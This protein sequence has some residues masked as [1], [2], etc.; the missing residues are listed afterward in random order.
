MKMTVKLVF[1]VLRRITSFQICLVCFNI[2]WRHQCCTA[3]LLLFHLPGFMAE[4]WKYLPKSQNGSCCPVERLF[5]TCSL[6]QTTG[7]KVICQYLLGTGTLFSLFLLLRWKQRCE[8]SSFPSSLQCNSVK[9]T[10]KK[11]WTWWSNV[12]GQCNQTLNSGTDS[13]HLYEAYEYADL[14]F[15]WFV[16]MPKTAPGSW[17]LARGPSFTNPCVASRLILVFPQSA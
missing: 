10:S 1:S 17:S 16:F 14:F 2:H 4:K 3:L 7:E 9:D 6:C 15:I 11:N 13:V 8:S 5:S 12:D